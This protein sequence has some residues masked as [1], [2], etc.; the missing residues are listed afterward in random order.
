MADVTGPGTPPATAADINRNADAVA[1]DVRAMHDA[2]SAARWAMVGTTLAI[3]LAI[4]IFGWMLYRHAKTNLTQEKVRTAFVTRVEEMAPQ[5]IPR[6]QEALIEVQP[7][8]REEAMRRLEKISPQLQQAFM[9]EAQE[10]P[11]ELRQELTAGLQRALDNVRRRLEADLQQK[12]PNLTEDQLRRMGEQL[13]SHLTLEGSELADRMQDMLREEMEKVNAA[14][15]EFP[16]PPVE[17]MES[18]ELQRAFLHNLLML[19]DYY[20]LTGGVDET[21]VTAG[22]QGPGMGQGQFPQLEGREAV[23][24]PDPQMLEEARRRAAE[25]A[26]GGAATQPARQQDGQPRRE[27]ARPQDGQPRQDPPATP[28]GP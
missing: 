22:G 12:F 23:R 11:E 16:L 7:V 24:Q 4:L 28:Q 18:D 19:A 15:E 13:Q 8:Y 10:L 14:L 3:L 6:F 20:V 1:A 25:R 9:R 5:Y 17:H 27:P 26:G 21:L 2:Q